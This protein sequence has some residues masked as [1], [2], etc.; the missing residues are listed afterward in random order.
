MNNKE[1]TPRHF[2][3]LLSKNSRVVES[4]CR[5]EFSTAILD[6]EGKKTVMVRYEEDCNNILHWLDY[7]E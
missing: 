3:C 6:A 1:I 4:E 7:P 2:V 5:K